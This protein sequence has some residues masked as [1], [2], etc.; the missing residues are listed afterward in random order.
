MET[1]KNEFIYAGVVC[2][3]LLL[4]Y[5]VFAVYAVIDTI[6]TELACS[7]AG[8]PRDT[9]IISARIGHERKNIVVA[10]EDGGGGGGSISKGK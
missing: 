5:A 9:H 1:G 2:Y 8:S 7:K 10:T 6:P 4:M 3:V